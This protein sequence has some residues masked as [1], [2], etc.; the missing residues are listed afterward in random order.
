MPD[1]LHSARRIRPDGAFRGTRLELHVDTKYIRLGALILAIIVADIITKQ[2][3]LQALTYGYTVHAL[4]G[5]LPLTLAFNKGIA[6]GVGL[7]SMGRW[8]IIGASIVI[9]VVLTRL[10]RETEVK[11]RVRLVAVGMVMAGAVGNLIDRL[12]WDQGVVDFIGPYN[13]GFMYWPIFNIADMA[14]TCGAVALGVSLWREE[15]KVAAA[16]KAG[17]AAVA[18]DR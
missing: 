13:L 11:D 3:A 12:R 8:L 16:G 17:S 9:L 6:F 15:A 18:R 5:A 4:G 14:I 2:W 10:A 7:P 1:R